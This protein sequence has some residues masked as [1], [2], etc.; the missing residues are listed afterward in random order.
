VTTD[1]TRKEKKAVLL[2]DPLP[3]K[4]KGKRFSEKGFGRGGLK[5]TTKKKIGVFTCFSCHKLGF[6]TRE[7]AR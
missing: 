2:R 3:L 1:K 7:K 4:K 5:G 6:E